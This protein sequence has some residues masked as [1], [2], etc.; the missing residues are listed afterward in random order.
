MAVLLLALSL[1]YSTYSL[2]RGRSKSLEE[3]QGQFNAACAWIAGQNHK[4]L[5]GPILTRHP[6]EVYLLTGRHALDV[7]TRERA[8]SRDATPEE[9]ADI[10]SRFR[11]AYLIIDDGRYANAPTSPLARYVNER[12]ESVHKV[13]PSDSREGPISI[14]AIG[15]HR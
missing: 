15:E 9:I 7:S 8:G 12:P 1:P 14:Y 6:G 4:S 11:V 2:F 13:W 10:I 5:T 3:T